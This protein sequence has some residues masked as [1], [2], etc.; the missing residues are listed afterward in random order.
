MKKYALMTREELIEFVRNS[1]YEFDPLVYA[2][3]AELEKQDRRIELPKSL[4]LLQEQ[5]L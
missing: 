3:V 2:L 1:K 5:A 4:H